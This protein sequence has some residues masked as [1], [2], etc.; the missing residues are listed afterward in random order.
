MQYFLLA[1]VLSALRCLVGRLKGFRAGKG[2]HPTLH[3]G[4]NSPPVSFE[5]KGKMY[6]CSSFTEQ[7]V[8]FDAYATRNG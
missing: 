6:S 2:G 5:Q 3:N 7:I 4:G 8:L 1:E